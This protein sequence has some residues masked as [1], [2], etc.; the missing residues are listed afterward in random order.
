[1]RGVPNRWTWRRLAA[2][3][4]QPHEGPGDLDRTRSEDDDEQRREDAQ[5]QGKQNLDR[6]LLGRPL[7]ALTTLE[8]SVLRLLAERGRHRDPELARLDEARH[9]DVQPRGRR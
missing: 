6:N 7:R 4:R 1:M 9:E 5:Q 8:T 3:S 2:L